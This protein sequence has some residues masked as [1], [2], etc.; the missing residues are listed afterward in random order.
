MIDAKSS[1]HSVIALL[2]LLCTRNDGQLK[3]FGSKNWRRMRRCCTHDCKGFAKDAHLQ[4][5]VDDIGIVL[6]NAG[7]V[8]R[9]KTLRW[10]CSALT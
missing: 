2:R 1:S 4:S 8:I 10:R 3:W 6:G 9:D 7:H 5:V